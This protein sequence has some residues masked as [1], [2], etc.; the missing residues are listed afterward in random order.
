MSWYLIFKVLNCLNSLPLDPVEK[1]FELRK[2][3]TG[4]C[5][6]CGSFCS[7]GIECRPEESK[8]RHRTELHKSQVSTDINHSGIENRHISNF[9]CLLFSGSTWMLWGRKQTFYG[10]DG[11]GRVDIWRDRCDRRSRQNLVDC[12]HFSENCANRLK[13]LQKIG[14]HSSLEQR[15]AKSVLGT[16]YEY[17]YY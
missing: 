13:L 17:E 2:G 5:P 7:N 6:F 14:Y 11:G 12:I 8:Q 15:W 10:R 3:C 16:K 9:C 4:Q 1:L